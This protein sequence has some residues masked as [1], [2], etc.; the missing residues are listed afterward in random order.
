MNV[1][2]FFLLFSLGILNLAEASSSQSGT[3]TT[4]VAECHGTE[5][6]SS[7]DGQ[8]RC[9]PGCE[10]YYYEEY[11][12]NYCVQAGAG[13]GDYVYGSS[14]RVDPNVAVQAS[15]QLIS[16]ALQVAAYSRGSLPSIKKPSLKLPKM[17]LPKFKM[18]NVKLPRLRMPRIRFRGRR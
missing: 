5:C 17:K 10:C 9:P 13:S 16:D 18:P 12:G 11:G 2:L 14:Q 4:K 8:T 15:T 7:A 6:I 1:A 3:T